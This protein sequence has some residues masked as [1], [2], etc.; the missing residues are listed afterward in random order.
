MTTVRDLLRDADPARHDEMHRDER[1]RMRRAVAAAAR[2]G[3][4]PAS[5]ARVMAVAAIAVAVMVVAG[6]RLWMGSAT[7]H[8]A[9]VRFEA[10]L[11]E[12]TPTLDLI[13][14]RVGDRTIYLHREAIVTNGD[15]AS[16]RVIPGDAPLQF[17]VAIVLT[18]AGAEKMGA[19]TASHL[20][21][22]LALMIDGS[23]VM[24]PTVR[25]AITSQQAVL[26][27]AYTEAEAERIASG[28]IGR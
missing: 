10:R 19:A 21:R 6:S 7:L 26:T 24:A 11:A 22:P 8:A 18:A 25:S 17:H 9:A 13:P 5:R 23:V 15:I 16:A 2:R 14:A 3:T 20:G 27:G 28:M 1:D 12:W 4:P